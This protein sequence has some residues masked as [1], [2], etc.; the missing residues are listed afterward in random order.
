MLTGLLQ[1]HQF[2]KGAQTE[3]VEADIDVTLMDIDE[4]TIP[5]YTK[6]EKN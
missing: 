5:V 4:S 3:D 1:Q 6:D 2:T